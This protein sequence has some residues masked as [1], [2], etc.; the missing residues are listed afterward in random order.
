MSVMFDVPFHSFRGGITD[1]RSAAGA[2]PQQL[3]NPD[4]C[5][6]RSRS[7]ATAGYPARR[8]PRVDARQLLTDQ[9][10]DQRTLRSEMLTRSLRATVSHRPRDEQAAPRA[11]EEAHGQTIQ[12]QRGSKAARAGEL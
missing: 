1:R 6:S 4:Q 5:S 9:L 10:I 3:P 7:A 12:T 2:A 8:W 11:L